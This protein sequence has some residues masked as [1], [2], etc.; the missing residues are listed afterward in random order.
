E[1]DDEV[2]E[3]ITE[4]ADGSYRLD[5][6]LAVRDINRRLD[7]NLPVSE[8]YTTVAGFLM[9][10]AGQILDEGDSLAYN[11]N[12]FHIEKVDKRRILQVRMERT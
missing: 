1:H 6:G 12:T 11:G 4:L 8:T 3:Q 5:G 10:E 7:V 9:A 2:N